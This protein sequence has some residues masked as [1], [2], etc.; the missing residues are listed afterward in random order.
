M[1]YLPSLAL[2]TMPSKISHQFGSHAKDMLNVNIS[3]DIGQGEMIKLLHDLVI[4][5]RTIH[6]ESPSEC[7]LCFQFS[8]S[9]INS[10]IINCT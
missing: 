10:V 2:E 3:S 6:E 7:I 4:G 9:K 5:N 1:V 8:P